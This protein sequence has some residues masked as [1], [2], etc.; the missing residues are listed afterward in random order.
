MIHSPTTHA[1]PS[2]KTPTELQLVCSEIWGGNRPVSTPVDL[3]G[4]RGVLYSEPADG[5]KGGDVHYLSVCGSGVLGA[6][7][8]CGCRRTW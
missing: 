2:T 8:H 7:V 4:M 5:R 1:D 3:P 6:P